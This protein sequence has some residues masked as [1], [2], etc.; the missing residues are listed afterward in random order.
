MTW[1]LI[2]P[3]LGLMCTP[4]GTWTKVENEGEE[5]QMTIFTYQAFDCAIWIVQAT[6]RAQEQ[7]RDDQFTKGDEKGVCILVDTCLYTCMTILS[8]NSRTHFSLHIFYWRC[9]HIL[10]QN[11]QIWFR[12]TQTHLPYSMGLLFIVESDSWF[13]GHTMVEAIWSFLPVSPVFPCC[14]AMHPFHDEDTNRGK[15]VMFSYHSLDSWVPSQFEAS[16]IL[17]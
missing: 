9:I 8:P 7:I 5:G 11:T 1:L 3:F 12:N 6:R 4:T 15:K 2:M 17:G 10:V 14:C 16:R 13:L